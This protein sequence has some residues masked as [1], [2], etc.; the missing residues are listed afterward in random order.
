VTHQSEAIERLREKTELFELGIHPN[1][2]SGSTHGKTEDEVLTHVMSIVPNAISMRTHGLYQTSNWLAKAAKE[3]GILVDVSL[4]L[5]RADNLSPHK[6]KWNGALLWRIPYFWGDNSE[7]FEDAPIWS[8]SD[9]RLKIHGLKV[10]DF[11]PI[12]IALNADRFERYEYLKSIRPLKF[13]D[14]EFIKKHANTDIG[15]QTLFLD[16]VKM[17]SGKGT[18]IR[19]IVNKVQ[20]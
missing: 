9:E 11:H 5:P 13:W 20:I 16:L 7:M 1:M 6:I 19:D 14:E 12:H 10:F 2:L 18:Q 3:Y 8:L 17:L 4:F 15:P